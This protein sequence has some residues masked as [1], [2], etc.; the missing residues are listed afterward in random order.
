MKTRQTTTGI[1]NNRNNSFAGR[2]V[3]CCRKVLQQIQ[4]AKQS[5]LSEYSGAIE[6]HKKLLQLALN[7]AEAIAWQTDYPHLIFATLAEEKAQAALSWHAR[8][9]QVRHLAL[10]EQ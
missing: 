8:Q 9:R 5:F 2:C 10:A 4:R 7:E 3:D 1:V 6:E